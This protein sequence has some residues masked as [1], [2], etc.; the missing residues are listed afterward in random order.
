MA[1]KGKYI[2]EWPRPMVTTDAAVFGFFDGGFKLALIKRGK[3][4]FKGQWAIPG[5]FVELDEELEH[6]AARELAE[7]TGLKNVTLEQMYTFGKCGRDPRGR[8][9]TIAFMGIMKDNFDLIKAGDDAADAKWF[10]IENLPENLAFDHE[11]VC[12][13]AVSRL[14]ET[15]EYKQRY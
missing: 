14:K 12:R 8:Q 2:Y 4:P 13:Y 10:N 9:I 7:E 11:D 3:E 15:T 1:K 5:G 6:A